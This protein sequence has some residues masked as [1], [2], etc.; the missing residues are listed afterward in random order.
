M[1]DEDTMRVEEVTYVGVS[2]DSAVAK[3]KDLEAE[4]EGLRRNKR[5]SEEKSKFLRLVGKEYPGAIVWD[6]E[7][8][9]NDECSSEDLPAS[10]TSAYDDLLKCASRL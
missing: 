4:K 7:I 3:I 5:W 2:L 8:T 1:D 9:V 6:D 10:L